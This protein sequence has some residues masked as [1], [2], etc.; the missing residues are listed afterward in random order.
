[1]TSS[2]IFEYYK[3]LESVQNY[4][5]YVVLNVWRKPSDTAIERNTDNMKVNG[6]SLKGQN[7]E[8]SS[9]TGSVFIKIDLATFAHWLKQKESV[10]D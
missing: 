7:I 6:Y 3:W 2:D 8:I 5:E 10:N 1:M 4:V 9:Y